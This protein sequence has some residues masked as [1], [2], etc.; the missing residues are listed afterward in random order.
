ME[1]PGPRVLVV[2]FVR[3]DLCFAR[4]ARAIG[5]ASLLAFAA[6]SGAAEPGTA[7]AIRDVEPVAI[8]AGHDATVC[9]VPGGALVAWSQATGDAT[10]RLIARR[11]ASDGEPLG[12]DLAPS[13]GDVDAGLPATALEVRLACRTDGSFL[14]LW[15]TTNPPTLWARGF[16]SSGAALGPAR[17]IASPNGTA[18]AD[19][20]VV[21]APSGDLAL[22]AT[23]EE[24]E[25][26]GE[27]HLRSLDASGAPLGESIAL[28]AGGGVVR[29]R[30]EA[31][32][33]I[34]GRLLV[35]WW[36]APYSVVMRPRAQ[37]FD[38]DGRGLGPSHRAAG[39]ALLALP[40]GGFAEWSG[41]QLQRYGAAGVPAAPIADEAR[42]DPFEIAGGQGLALLADGRLFT[43]HRADEV[44]WPRAEG[45]DYVARRLRVDFA[46]GS[47]AP[48]RVDVKL[49]RTR[50]REAAEWF[51]VGIESAEGALVGGRRE[52]LV[53]VLD[54]FRC[55]PYQLCLAGGRFAAHAWYQH[56]WTP[57][58]SPAT[59]LPAPWNEHAGT[60]SFSR[61]SRVPDVLL[62]L[63]PDGDGWSIPHGVASG[64][65]STLV[66]ADRRTHRE[67][68]WS[69][70]NAFD[71][72]GRPQPPCGAGEP[73]VF[74]KSSPGWPSAARCVRSA[75]RLCLL[76]GRYVL[77]ATW[78]DPRD[79][80]SGRAAAHPLSSRAGILTFDDVR[81]PELLAKLL[82]SG[83]GILFL[84]GSAT[85][86]EYAVTVRELATG[87]ERVYRRGEGFCG[88]IDPDA[89]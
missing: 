22:W 21:A 12:E 34:D 35:T 67:R 11:H 72:S 57:Q 45:K 88:V 37:L 15:G 78:R 85:D 71:G 47:S 52:T 5:V 77:S 32:L 49:V 89:F 56:A 38:L 31:A 14:V 64:F 63:A 29:R 87:R 60:F 27:V 43:V 41:V 44:L 66:V 86:F 48:A 84:S 36:E 75:Q 16:A 61:D 26:S 59:A 25:A 10:H 9:S 70:G 20:A 8:A 2:R 46:A 18:P 51:T 55:E 76:D 65:E 1:V 42:P 68:S 39:G 17:A 13:E 69:R 7:P 83:D 54:E 33:G 19:A 58:S 30:P 80:R 3:S 24:L 62:E 6:P 23:N 74:P 73:L 40:A 53:E 82:D 4:C 79:G 50:R 81:S 28:V